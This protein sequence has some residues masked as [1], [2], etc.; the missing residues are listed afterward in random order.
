MI[1]QVE[2]YAK[3]SMQPNADMDIKECELNQSETASCL[4]A[5]AFLDVYHARLYKR[6]IFAI[7]QTQFAKLKLRNNQTIRNVGMWM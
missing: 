3:F 1:K 7:T 5:R 4:C 6:S 2:L